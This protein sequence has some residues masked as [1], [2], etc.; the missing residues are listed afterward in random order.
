MVIQQQSMKLIFGMK[1]EQ[2]YIN[3]MKKEKNSILTIRLENP[4]DDNT[5]CINVETFA[6]LCTNI[7]IFM[8]RN[9]MFKWLRRNGYIS[10]QKGSW[11]MPI[12]RYMNQNLFRVKETF[13]L[14]NDEQIPKY[15]PLITAKGQSYLMDKLVRNTF[16]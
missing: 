10:E 12:Q 7:G 16:Y 14:Y 13:I 2:N 11:N 5:P 15:S 3:N 4:I 9:Q 6:K 1:N 8:G